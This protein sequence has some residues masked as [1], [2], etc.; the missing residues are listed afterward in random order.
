M[1]KRPNKA[2]EI[3][4]DEIRTL[5]S[6]FITQEDNKLVVCWPFQVI[7]LKSKVVHNVEIGEKTHLESL[8][9]EEI[10]GNCRIQVPFENGQVLGDTL[11][12]KSYQFSKL[13]EVET[14]DVEGI[15]L[16]LIQDRFDHLDL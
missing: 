5:L 9:V 2:D 4:L 16:H 12:N 14:S 1:D 8:L 15:F 11:R 10:L 3:L 7:T 6:H 13:V